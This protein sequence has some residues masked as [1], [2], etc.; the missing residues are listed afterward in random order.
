M[1]YQIVACD[2]D[3]RKAFRHDEMRE[4]T[5]GVLIGGSMH[6]CVWDWR[7]KNLDQKIPGDID[8]H[9]HRRRHLEVIASFKLEFL[10]RQLSTFVLAVSQ[11]VSPPHRRHAYSV[12]A[13]LLFL[14][15]HYTPFFIKRL[16]AGAI[17]WFA[18]RSDLLYDW[19]S[20]PDKTNMES[21]QAVTEY[22]WGGGNEEE[23]RDI[24]CA[25]EKAAGKVQN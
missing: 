9:M 24:G 5:G 18:M 4:L 21:H 19:S 2:M 1:W 7:L 11:H 17:T 25:W 16:A 12:D 6:V 20:P 3:R 10:P 13:N 23:K 22:M 15:T 14:C 8:T